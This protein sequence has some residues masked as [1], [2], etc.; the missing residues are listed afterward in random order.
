MKIASIPMDLLTE[1]AKIC[2]DVE[3][4]YSIGQLV[5][6]DGIAAQKLVHQA[7]AAGKL[8]R[9]DVATVI[10]RVELAQRKRKVALCGQD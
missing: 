5:K 4:L 8:G 2:Q 7:V 1:L 6:L 3:A 10:D 9:A